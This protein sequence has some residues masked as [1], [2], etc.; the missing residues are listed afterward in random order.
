MKFTFNFIPTNRYNNLITQKTMITYNEFQKAVKIILMYKK[1]LL[2]PECCSKI[3][4]KCHRAKSPKKIVVRKFAKVIP[5]TKVLSVD[6]SQRLYNGL[7]NHLYHFGKELNW[8]TTINDLSKISV[9][10]FYRERSTGTTTI[11]ELI[12]LCDAAGIDLRRNED[13]YRKNQ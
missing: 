12:S 7:R 5:E 8:E 2:C 1:Q 13:N 4:S 9:E 6:C 11:Q 3:C 10:A